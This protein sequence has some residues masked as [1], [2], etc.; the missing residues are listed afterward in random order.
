MDPLAILGEGVAD[1]VAEL[2]G[3]TPAWSV[4]DAALAARVDGLQALPNRAELESL[5]LAIR[6]WRKGP[7]S[8]PAADGVLEIDAE[9]RADWKWER[10]SPLLDRSVIEGAA[11]VD[12]G[13]GNGYYLR[14]LSEGRPGV[15]LGIDPQPRAV[16][17]WRLAKRLGRLLGEP[18]WENAS[19]RRWRLDALQSLPGCFDV[20]LCAGLLYHV[21]DPIEALRTLRGALAP[22][23]RIVIE[24][25][26]VPGDDPIAWTPPRRYA[27]ARGFWAL[28]TRPCLEAWIE[29]AGLRVDAWTEPV[30]TT[31]EEQRATPW[32]FG[33]GIAAGLDPDDSTRT[34]E[35]LPAP[36][37]VAA[38]LV[39]G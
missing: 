11:V 15:L 24:T 38:V 7:W 5:A 16:L 8:L 39:P 2:D 17:Q 36:W 23:G 31:P 4:E 30:R 26:I 18:G 21:T 29:R 13:C 20:V 6:P 3:A 9:W 10:L 25:I 22:G 34:V 14:R 32:T 27:G 28:P 33:P 37:R 12:V 19:L 1:R 35:G